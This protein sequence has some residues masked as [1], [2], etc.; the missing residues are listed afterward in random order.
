[1]VGPTPTSG[2]LCEG[3]VFLLLLFT[4]PPVHEVCPNYEVV[5][6]QSQT[7]TPP[8][9]GSVVNFYGSYSTILN[10]LL[11]SLPSA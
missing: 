1:M 11:P 7:A 6:F 8:Y 3:N 2:G 5:M 10:L 9:L 4:W